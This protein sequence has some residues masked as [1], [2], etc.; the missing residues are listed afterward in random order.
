MDG[1][2]LDAMTTAATLAGLG[3]PSGTPLPVS[4]REA[5]LKALGELALAASEAELFVAQAVHYLLTDTPE[6]DAG[7]GTLVKSVNSMKGL[8]NLLRCAVGD[9]L[10]VQLRDLVTESPEF[11]E[12][13]GPAYPNVFL[14]DLNYNGYLESTCRMSKGTTVEQ[15]LNRVQALY[16]R[17]NECLHAFV[18]DSSTTP[19]KLMKATKE[20]NTHV[21]PESL[22]EVCWDTPVYPT[23]QSVMSRIAHELWMT[24]IFLPTMMA[25]LRWRR[26]RSAPLEIKAAFALPPEAEAPPEAPPD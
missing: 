18:L 11:L 1:S 21:S 6:N 13:V 20:G 12:V 22:M 26:V 14:R 2:I 23:L 7:V 16:D 3:P 19:N 24:A 17:R 8:L 10:R 25:V 5:I 15:M 9:D 4:E